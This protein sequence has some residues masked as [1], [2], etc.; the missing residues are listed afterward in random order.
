MVWEDGH[1]EPVVFRP[2]KIQ[3]T[4][5]LADLLECNF[6]AACTVMYRKGLFAEHPVWLF[7]TP[8][9]DW[10]HH[11][12]HARYGKIGYIDE[13]MGVYRQH[14][15]GV[16]SGKDE[17]GRLRVAIEML[18]HFLCVVD[19][20]HRRVV[21]HSLCLHY[22]RLAWEYC[23]REQYDEARQCMKECLREVRP[24]LHLPTAKLL[25]TLSRVHAPGF[26]HGCKRI[27]KRKNPV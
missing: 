13:P 22:C 26:H 14:A 12:L 24:G 21:N 16:Y 4:Y 17:T 1:R 20:E 19:R 7:L 11:V 23:D 27:L 3:S 8:V 9:M 6:I 25:S 18:R 10:A 5:G 15:G 2:G